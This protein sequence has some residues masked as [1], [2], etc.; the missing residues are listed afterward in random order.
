MYVVLFFFVKRW[1]VL[2]Q[3]KV[4]GLIKMESFSLCCSIYMTDL[5]GK[6]ASFE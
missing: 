3:I 5:G 1:N 6:N 4:F 2:S